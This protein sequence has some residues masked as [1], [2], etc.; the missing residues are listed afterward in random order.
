[1]YENNNK[2]YF[3]WISLYQKYSLF[4]YSFII[5]VGSFCG[6]FEWYQEKTVFV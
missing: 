5:I 4:L 3:Y 2:R 6:N 1:M